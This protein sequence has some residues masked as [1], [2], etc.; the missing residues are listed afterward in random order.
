[1]NKLAN[2]DYKREIDATLSRV[3][4]NI[5]ND[6]DF[7]N[8]FKVIQEQEKKLNDFLEPGKTINADQSELVVLRKWNSY[9][10]VLPE[11]N[12]QSNNKGG[13]YFIIHK[14]IG[15]VIDPGYNFIENFFEA[16]FQIDD[17]DYIFV[18]HAHDDHTGQLES[19]FSLLYKRNNN[20]NDNNYHKIKLYLNLGTFKKFANLINLNTHE[21][22]EA[23]NYIEHI[24]ILN[25]HQWIEIYEKS[26]NNETLNRENPTIKVF[27]SKVKHHE[28]ITK[29]YAIGLT[30]VLNN[31]N[32]AD[33]ETEHVIKFT[34][35]TGWDTEIENM[36]RDLLNVDKIDLLIAHLGSIKKKET[37]YNTSL[38]LIE[39]E[40]SGED[41]FYTNHLGIIGTIAQIK[42]WDPKIVLLSEFG[43]EINI[44][45]VKLAQFLEKQL[46]TKIFPVDLNFRI[47][48]SDFKI[49]CMKT[50]QYCDHEEIAFLKNVSDD[51]IFYKNIKLT[52]TEEM[53]PQT[54]VNSINPYKIV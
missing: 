51:I 49:R 13:G 28:T 17:I 41:I 22:E 11:N 30:F 26:T 25:L 29:H 39:N 6:T 31:F 2:I 36:N 20:R 52:N 43:R 48:L 44:I 9:T 37:N 8:Y 47:N 45:R 12:N 18:T 53:D 5:K 19:I 35:D 1:M 7:S 42:F 15:I 23:N 54:M 14:G 4:E 38:K 32:F 33:N 10:P 3:M 34:S 50:N 24:V 27:A 21:S 16:G 40:N 46:S